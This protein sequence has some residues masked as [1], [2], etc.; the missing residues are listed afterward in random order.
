KPLVSSAAA[1]PTKS[2]SP[3]RISREAIR[4]SLSA[5]RTPDQIASHSS[6]RRATYLIA[7]EE[8]AKLAGEFCTFPATPE[9]VVMLRDQRQLRWER[10][11]VR[12]TGDPSDT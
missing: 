12:L 1:Q 2:S 10:I 3:S 9:S 5:G 7:L 4:D 6:Q 8:E 11:A